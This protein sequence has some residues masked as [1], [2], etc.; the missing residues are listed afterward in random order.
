MPIVVPSLPERPHREFDRNAG[1]PGTRNQGAT[2]LWTVSKT[3]EFHES[4]KISILVS[5]VSY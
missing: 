4:V 2:Y 1:D 5:V 3:Q